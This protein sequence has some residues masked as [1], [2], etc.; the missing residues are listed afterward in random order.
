M[1][2]ARPFIGILLMVGA[3]L[4]FAALD[5]TSKHLTQTFSVPMLVW[6]RYTVHLVL[7]VIFLAPS[8]RARLVATQRPVA[9]TIRALMLVGTTGFAMAGISIMPLA[10]STAFLFVTPLIVVILASWL[11]KE[12]VS[13]GRWIA[14]IT[15]FSGVLL[16]ARPG[17]ALSTQ[18]I[19]LMALAAGCYAIYQVQT[20]QMS[21]TENTV[22]MLF[23]T[24]LVGTL[25]MSL[26][27]P[28]Y[29]G[30]PMPNPWQALSIASLGIY[31]GTGHLLMTRAFRH[32]PAS[33]LSPFLYTQLIWA[34]LLGW[35]FYDHLP[36]LLSI[37][38]MAVI[39]ASS[40]SIALS[41]RFK[42]AGVA[43]DTDT[44]S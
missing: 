25:S 28:L 36:D 18:G 40:L 9:L 38:G 42:Q 7:M 14:I 10:E 8:M 21:V 41:E 3:G 29:W 17:G 44:A 12:S 39:A 31:G 13:A 16:I 26:A 34:I 6:A 32:A 27:A 33:T 30:G 5:A 11:L 23:Y 37:A 22:T 24:A 19:F 4:C 1:S 43:K 15:G 2:D 20:R 35:L